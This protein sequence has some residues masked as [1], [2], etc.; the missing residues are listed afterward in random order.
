MPLEE[1]AK[2]FIQRLREAGIPVKS[3]KRPPGESQPYYQHDP[4]P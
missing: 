2:I 4:S 1:F 3:V